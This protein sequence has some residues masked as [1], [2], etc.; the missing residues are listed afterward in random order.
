MFRRFLKSAS[1]NANTTIFGIMSFVAVAL[2]QARYLF[3][4]LPATNPDWNLV[5]AA[6]LVMLGLVTAKDAS[7]PKDP[8]NPPKS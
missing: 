2:D 4:D 5:A 3:D 6:F 1:S 8:K 7:Q